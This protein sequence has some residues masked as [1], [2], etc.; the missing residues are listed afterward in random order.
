MIF[1]ISVTVLGMIFLYPLVKVL[2]TEKYF[3]NKVVLLK[4]KLKDYDSYDIPVN[5]CKNVKYENFIRPSGISLSI[6]VLIISLL[7]YISNFTN[8]GK[9]WLLAV[10]IIISI[11]FFLEFSFMNVFYNDK[12][13]FLKKSLIDYNSKNIPLSEITSATSTKSYNILQ[14]CI[15][16]LISLI[17]TIVLIICMYLLAMT[18]TRIIIL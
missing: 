8:L 15:I 1:V 17:S 10:P 12:M 16:S 6:L 9:I 14:S 3:K 2:L 11:F 7:S 4:K 5:E 18:H 13:V